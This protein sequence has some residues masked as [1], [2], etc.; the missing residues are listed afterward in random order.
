MAYL[1][2]VRKSEKHRS[3][4]HRSLLTHAITEGK[5]V[6]TALGSVKFDMDF[7]FK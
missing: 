4:D 5:A 2:Q 7:V 3:H 1:G 6:D